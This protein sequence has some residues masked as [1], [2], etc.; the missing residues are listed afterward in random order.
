[1]RAPGEIPGMFA[2]ESAH[3]RAG[4]RACGV[5]P[6]ELRVRNE[7][8]EDP[9]TGKPFSTRNLVAC[10]RAGPSG[11]A[12]PSGRRAAG[13]RRD[14]EWWSAWEWRARRTRHVPCP[15]TGRASASP[16]GATGSRCGPVD[17]GTGARTV[18]PQIAAEAL[19]V[20]VDLVDA[21]IVDSGL[22][23]AI[24]AGGSVGTSSGATRSSPP[25]ARSAPS[26]ATTRT[27]GVETTASAPRTRR[28]AG[29]S[30]ALLR[31]PLRPGAGQPVTGEVRVARLLGVFSAGRV[32]NPRTARSQLIGGMMM[33][34]SAALHEE[35]HLD[36][37]FGHVVNHDLAG[38]HVAAHA[39]VV[40]LEADGSTRR[41]PC[42]RD[43]RQGHRR[44]RHRRHRAAIGNAVYNASGVRVRDL[45]FT[46]DRFFE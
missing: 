38:Y 35:S 26:T 29:D 25:P 3:G 23:W 5:D 36:P 28:V 21:E 13:T 15:A 31:C 2:L 14:G 32:I 11:S 18:L 20:G 41:N 16:T 42:S 39:D 24:S 37:R 6:V 1:M 27:R 33:G 22:P 46:A 34:L 12:G 9:E 17:I 8:E 45:P 10:L 44:D 43:G 19:G 30:R 4:R 7:P 40:G